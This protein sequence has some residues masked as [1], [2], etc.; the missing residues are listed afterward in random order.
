MTP[1]TDF[2]S[3]HI[4]GVSAIVLALLTWVVLHAVRDRV[5]DLW[6]IG[7]LMGGGYAFVT[8]EVI[9]YLDTQ[10]G[11][12]ITIA[13]SF[14]QL[15][16]FLKWISLRLMRDVSVPWRWAITGWFF[17]SFMLA[18]LFLVVDQVV[19]ATRFVSLFNAIL[20]LAIAKE[21]W[22]IARAEKN[23]AGY[24]LGVFVGM[25]GVL[26]ALTL[27]MPIPEGINP[28]IPSGLPASW[29]GSAVLFIIAAAANAFF[30]GLI[31]NR[32]LRENEASQRALRLAERERFRTE[33]RERLLAD[34]HDGLGSQLAT[35]RMKVERSELN[36]DE[37][38][39]LLREC[40][41]DLH[42]MVD[43]L[44]EDS[45]SFADALADYRFRTER[46][47]SDRSMQMVW[48][49]SV[50]QMP[51]LQQRALLELLRILQEGINNA[52]RHAQASQLQI[53]ARFD[54]VGG[55]EMEI[56][57]D[58]VGLPQPLVVRRGVNNM[59]RR[60]RA[61]GATLELGPRTDGQ[62]GTRVWLTLSREELKP[63]QR[64]SA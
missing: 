2:D 59:H 44:R 57:D 54:P 7:G 25:H 15:G 52:V 46:R 14:A 43:T 18:I 33:E 26:F 5:V 36:Q 3:L 24:W 60:A 11:L 38:V 40:M 29:V 4:T 23:F 35:A 28:L 51:P 8:A 16:I 64:A 9:P 27:A 63:L 32:A 53:T 1:I 45:H 30:I 62:P 12:A 48:S 55:L 56:V 10:V 6:C 19:W 42:L 50:D 41:A 21:A 58:G 47:L 31:L 20:A 39:E 22:C 37:V 34:M 61:I 13:L 49:V 17:Y